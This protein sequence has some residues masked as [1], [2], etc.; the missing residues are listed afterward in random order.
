MSLFYA[1]K[2]ENSIKK[3]GTAYVNAATAL[4]MTNWCLLENYA[5]S[6]VGFM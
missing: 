3:C 4:P 1:H 6:R 2:K 5:A